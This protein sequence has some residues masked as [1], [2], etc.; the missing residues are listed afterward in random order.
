MHRAHTHTHKHKAHRLSLLN[1]HSLT[2]TLMHTH[3]RRF[4]VGSA[5]QLR[6]LSNDPLLHACNKEQ[7]E[8]LKKSPLDQACA[9][10]NSYRTPLVLVTFLIVT[11]FSAQTT[12]AARGLPLLPYV[13]LHVPSVASGGV[14]SCALSCRRIVH[15][16]RIWHDG[17]EVCDDWNQEKEWGGRRRRGLGRHG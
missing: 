15:W 11:L 3:L 2:Y 13:L 14:A 9:C 1:T 8:L 7:R 16:R 10:Q 6:Y 5:L 12:H 4:G 17:H